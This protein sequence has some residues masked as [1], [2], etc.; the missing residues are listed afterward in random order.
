MVVH[1]RGGGRIRIGVCRRQFPDLRSF[2]HRADAQHQLAALAELVKVDF[3]R[4][5]D[6]GQHRR[7]EQY[8]VE[9]PELSGSSVSLEKLIHYECLVRSAPPAI[10]H[11]WTSWPAGSR[12]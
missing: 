8:L 11:L 3:E 2:A 5:W 6:A 12:H 9:Y 1:R 4:R 7:I 10:R